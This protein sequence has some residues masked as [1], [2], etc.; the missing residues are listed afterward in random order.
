M[1]R[2]ILVILGFC[3]VLVMCD[4][5]KSVL[6]TGASFSSLDIAL[7]FK[8][9]VYQGTFY[10]VSVNTDYVIWIENAARQYVKTLRITPTAVTVGTHGSHVEH[11]PAWMAKSGVTYAGLSGLTTDGIPAP[12]DAMTSASPVFDGDTVIT[13]TVNWDMKDQDGK[14]VNTGVYYCCAEAA[15]LIKNTDNDT[16]IIAEN[17]AAS[18]DL[19]SGAVTAASPTAH[20]LE[21]AIL[22]KE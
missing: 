6:E 17:T 20:I 4:R 14:P 16:Q 15:N 19:E 12:F 9:P 8:G 3:I 22:P 21:I 18:I 11:L 10:N 13:A 1:K 7:K 5:S 2:G